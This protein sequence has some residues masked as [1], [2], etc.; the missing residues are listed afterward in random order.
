MTA[1]SNSFGPICAGFWS[2]ATSS[3]TQAIPAPLA[4]AANAGNRHV[5]CRG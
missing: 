2:T 5:P 1:T 4:R 3:L